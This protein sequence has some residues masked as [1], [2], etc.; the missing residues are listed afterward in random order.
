MERWPF[1]DRHTRPDLGNGLAFHKQHRLSDINDVVYEDALTQFPIS[2]SSN[3][4]GRPPL[5]VI[6]TQ[7][8]LSADARQRIQNLV[9]RNQMSVF[10]REAVDNELRRREQASDSKSS[11][12]P[13]KTSTDD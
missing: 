6:T 5:N 11:A 4:M 9:G 3:R 13:G 12:T 2:V 10:I 7:V 1:R 8:R